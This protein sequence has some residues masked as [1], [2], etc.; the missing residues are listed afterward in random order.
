M[1]P[2]KVIITGPT[3]AIG[4]ALIDECL[5]HGD[6]VYAVCRPGSERNKTIVKDARVHVIEYD[7]SGLMGAKDVLPGDCGVFYHFA[8]AGTFGEARNDMSLQEKNIQYAL[9]AVNLAKCCGCHTF[10]GAGSQ[11]EYGRVEGV[12]KPD[13]PTFPENG[14]GM[15]KLCAGEMTR[16]EA[17]KLGMKH[18]WTRILS[19]YGPYD[20]DNTMVMS[21]IR[22]LLK[23]EKPSF[24]PGDQRWDYLYAKDAGGIM[25]ALGTEKSLDGR[26]YVLGRGQAQP[27]KEYIWIIRDSIDPMLPLGF[28]EIPYADKQVMH[29]CADNSGIV[30]DLGYEYRYDF[31]QGIMETIQYV[32]SNLCKGMDCQNG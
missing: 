8:W 26:V 3:G 1:E 19:V 16:V 2:R 9:D 4:H 28:G 25:Y 14:Y 30:N 24:T 32:K 10:I 5:A 12:L 6:E 22:K 7:L 31:S 21:T 18:I 17:H 15:A 20:G 11:A 27:L 29:L 13:T 23:G